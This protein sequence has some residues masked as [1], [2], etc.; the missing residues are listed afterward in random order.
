M[1]P[2]SIELENVNK[3]FEY[4]KFSRYLDSI[5]DTN[6]LRDFAKCYFKLYL[7]QQEVLVNL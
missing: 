6:T 3:L 2:N 4:E 5:D 7:R 1:N